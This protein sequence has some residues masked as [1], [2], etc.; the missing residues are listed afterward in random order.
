MDEL[1][2]IIAASPDN[3][4]IRNALVKCYEV[5]HNH[6]KIVCSVSGGGDSDVMLDMLL[7]CGARGQTDFV[8]FNTGLEYQATLEHLKVLED[9]YEITIE[10]IRPPKSIPTCTKEYGIPF[11][12]KYASDMIRRLQ[13]HNFKWEDKPFEDLYREYPSCKSALR[14]WCNVHD[15]NTTQWSIERSPYLKEFLIEN[16]PDFHISGMCCQYTKKTPIHRIIQNGKYDL[17][18]VGIRKS[19]GG[20]RSMTYKSCFTEKAAIGTDVFRPI[21]WLRDSDKEEYCAHYG[22]TH[23]KC[24]TEYG[25]TRTGCVGCPFGR[26]IDSELSTL[27]R[28]EPK[29]YKAAIAVFGKSYDYMQA[30]MEYRKKKKEEEICAR[31]YS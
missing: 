20:I 12:S 31:K 5:V 9:K 10:R 17:S 16:P 2:E 14:W 1:E 30:Y 27:S 29:L 8:F 26:N 23:S 15:G 24:Y 28:Y 18:C 25:L 21:F 22:V 19:E 4:V 11:W 6:D 7:R 3:F 13:M